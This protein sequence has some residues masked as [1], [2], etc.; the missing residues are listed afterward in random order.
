VWQI[1]VPDSTSPQVTSTRSSTS[2]SPTSLLPAFEMDRVLQIGELAQATVH[3]VSP[4]GLSGLVALTRN[5][6]K[7][8]RSGARATREV[9]RAALTRSA[10]CGTE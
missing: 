6:T 10:F 9:T 3:P 5:D 7:S 4:D 8:K 1:R 2:L